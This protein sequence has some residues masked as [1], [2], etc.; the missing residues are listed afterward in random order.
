VQNLAEVAEG[1]NARVLRDVVK[2]L[3]LLN[4]HRKFFEA[5]H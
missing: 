4:K 1:K 5:L 3:I 2:D